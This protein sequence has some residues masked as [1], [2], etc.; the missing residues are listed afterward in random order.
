MLVGLEFV[1]ISANQEVDSVHLG[2][3]EA[4]NLPR[5]P[6]QCVSVRPRI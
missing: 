2:G 1:E 4:D 5:A 6:P 3:Q